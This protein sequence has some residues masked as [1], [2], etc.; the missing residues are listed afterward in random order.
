MKFVKNNF[1]FKNKM[2]TDS[3]VRYNDRLRDKIEELEKKIREYNKNIVDN[4]TKL[5]FECDHSWLIDISDIGGSSADICEKCGLYN[6]EY[7]YR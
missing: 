2:D 4:E 3:I 1:I 5:F 6:N 7:M